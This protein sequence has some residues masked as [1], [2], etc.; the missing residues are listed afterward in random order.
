MQK[1]VRYRWL[2]IG[3]YDLHSLFVIFFSRMFENIHIYP[4]AHPSELNSDL[5]HLDD[6]D[7]LK[8]TMLDFWI[9]NKS[10]FYKKKILWH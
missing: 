7:G 3:N 5:Q 10:V 9:W 8:Q 6:T 2:F 1:F 4:S